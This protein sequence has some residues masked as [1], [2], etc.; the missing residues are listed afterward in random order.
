VAKSLPARNI[1]MP[2]PNGKPFPLQVPTADN[3]LIK[4]DTIDWTADGAGGI[5]HCQPWEKSTG[6]RSPEDK[7]RVARNAYKGGARL[8][9]RSL[10][11]TLREL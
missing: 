7:G 3:T 11:R 6:P 2:Y 4:A 5:R 10:A 1:D 8:M 9:L